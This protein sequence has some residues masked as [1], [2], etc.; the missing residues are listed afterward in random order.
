MFKLLIRDCK[1]NCVKELETLTLT[2]NERERAIQFR[3]D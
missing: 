3:R 2:Y 1:M